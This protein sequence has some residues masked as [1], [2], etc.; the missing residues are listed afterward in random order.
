MQQSSDLA[1]LCTEQ[2]TAMND[3]SAALENNAPEAKVNEA[4]KKMEGVLAKL[5]ALKMSEDAKK[6]ILERY[7]DDFTKAGTRLAQATMN[8]ARGDISKAFGHLPGMTDQSKTRAI[9]QAD[10]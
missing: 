7:K 10:G 2:I 3:L 5:A 4:Q 8:R 6:S 1:S 9:P